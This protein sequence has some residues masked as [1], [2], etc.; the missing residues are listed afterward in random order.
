MKFAVHL[1]RYLT[2]FGTANIVSSKVASFE[3]DLEKVEAGIKQLKEI[4]LRD[5]KNEIHRSNLRRLVDLVGFHYGEGMN[6]QS[7]LST[8]F[9]H[10]SS[11][12]AIDVLGCVKNC[13]EDNG[14]KPL[15]FPVPTQAPSYYYSKYYESERKRP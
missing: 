3:K 10:L 6:G 15:S 13:M 14:D 7:T 8:D 4:I 5:P 1:L 2:F 11:M 12:E 9:G